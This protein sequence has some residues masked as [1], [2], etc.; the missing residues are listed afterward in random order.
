[1]SGSSQLSKGLCS[2]D[3]QPSFVFLSFKKETRATAV[4]GHDHEP[5]VLCFHTALSVLICICYMHPMY[6][7]IIC[8]MNCK[9]RSKWCMTKWFI[10][11]LS[12]IPYKQQMRLIQWALCLLSCRYISQ[13]WDCS[14]ELQKVHSTQWRILFWTYLINILKRQY[15]S[16]WGISR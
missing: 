2:A 9:L 13:S 4:V 10:Q 3:S 8:F 16:S 1:M 15:Y 14:I 12:F 11:L 7:S 6:I 5:A